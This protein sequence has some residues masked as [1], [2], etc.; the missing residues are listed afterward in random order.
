MNLNDIKGS[1]I[2][3]VDDNPG[4]LGVLFDYL[5]KLEFIILVAQTGED[6]L[7]LVGENM[8]DIILLDILM[9]GIDGF[10]TCQRLKATNKTWDIPVLF[11]SSLSETIDKVKGFEAGG[12]DYITKPF[13][14]E[15]VLARIK[16]HLNLRNLKNQLKKQNENLLQEIGERKK[17][18]K[19]SRIAKEDAES[20]SRAKSAFL[21]NM[22]H[23][24]RTP[25]NAIMGFT[26][27]LEQKIVDKEQKQYLSLIRAGGKSL[28]SLINDILDLSKIEA[29]KLEPE[30]TAADICA[31]LEDI[32]NI[33]S[34][35][36][37]E[38]KLDF[39]LE[40]DPNLQTPLF[41]DETRIRQILL[42][43]VGNAIKFTESG[44]VKLIVKGRRPNTKTNMTD[45]IFSV[46]DTGIGIPEDQRELIFKPFEQ[47][48]GQCNSKYG[49]TG[50]G[51]SITKRLVEIMG[52]TISVDG[53]QDMGSIFSVSIKNIRIAGQCILPEK[54][55]LEKNNNDADLIIF[56]K[57]LIMIAD[58]FVD[59]RMLLMEYLKKFHFRFI[60]A[61]N[62]REAVE[63][64]KSHLPD[65]ILMDIRMPIIDGRDAA[66]ILKNFDKT[67]NIPVI[68]VTASA[69]KASEKEI[70]SLCDGYLKK[71]VSKTD[72]IFEISKFLKYSINNSDRVDEE[73]REKTKQST[74]NI[75]HP[76]TLKRLPELHK[77]LKEM[78]VFH[79][80]IS[81]ILT[82]ND[83]DDFA[84]QM[85]NL[86][87]EYKY[88]YLAE[89]GKQLVF[90]AGMFDMEAISETLKQFHDII[91]NIKDLI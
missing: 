17:A 47:Q 1:K 38:K 5:S 14:Q 91:K 31:V 3:I 68:A 84:N 22:S 50:L 11:I 74:G 39:I 60:E 43:L 59:N 40:T 33:F 73:S 55:N 70:N 23:E 71:P 79:K 19:E 42:N 86:G 51:L 30:Y 36:I 61:E 78:I 15:E 4:N 2:L 12:V 90:Q 20:A 35:K 64:A 41:F 87:A 54:K 28:L 37:K 69:M 65:L 7:E 82:I 58:D 21:A 62:G 88:D 76:E 77:I 45:I 66:R 80:N 10:E 56:D 18:E 75:I 57:A 16:T 72:L 32:K 24:I 8:P 48:K 83:I 9:P 29:G 52:G 67:K 13:Q 6:A 89:W 44:Y 27:I 34:Y 81:E 85:I 63:M 26:D 49:G 53:R 25:M 46:E